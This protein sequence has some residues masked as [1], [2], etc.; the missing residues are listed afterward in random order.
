MWIDFGLEAC[1]F[2]YAFLGLAIVCDNYLV[3]SLET[4]CIRWHVR[5]DVAGA[6]F[7]ALGSAAP[8][9][10][11]NAISTYKNADSINLG[12]GAIMG[13]SLIAF[14]LIP[15]CCAVFSEPLDL[16]R[17]PLLRDFSVYSVALLSLVYSLSNGVIDLHESLCL[18][19][20][21]VVYMMLVFFSPWV[22]YFYRHQYLLEPVVAQTSFVLRVKEEEDDDDDD[23]ELEQLV[24]RFNGYETI[25]RGQEDEERRRSA[26]QIASIP[27][28]F[29]FDATCPKNLYPVSLLMSFAWVS[30]FSIII[31]N[32]VEHW[33]QT[34]SL[35]LSLFG[36]LL[37]AFGAEVPDLVQSVVTARRG[38]GS[39]AVSNAIGSQICNICVGLGLPWTMALLSGQQIRITDEQHIKMAAY[40]QFIN[41][42]VLLLLLFAPVVFYK[43]NKALLTPVKGKLLIAAYLVIASSYVFLTIK[44]LH[45]V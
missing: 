38:Y 28:V 26:L 36:Y 6:S 37:V 5:E 27:L 30:L 1:L 33:G 43:S 19:G 9:I 3:P 29:F 32:V 42:G 8:E 45:L 18:L 40:L 13:S 22:R 25:E 35:P 20:L 24:A 31:S 21:Y 7:M 2:L 11:V 39:M 15:G 16:K 41:L 17:R 14:S 4:L 23:E 34:S 10:I 12:V 44:N